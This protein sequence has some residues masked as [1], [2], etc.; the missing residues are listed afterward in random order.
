MRECRW[1]MEERQK[2]RYDWNLTENG[3]RQKENKNKRKKNMKNK[4]IKE[5]KN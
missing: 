3:K 2:F 5:N 1:K 4:N